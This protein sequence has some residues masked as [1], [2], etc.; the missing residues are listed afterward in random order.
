V[1]VGSPTALEQRREP[2]HSLAMGLR[3]T[4]SVLAQREAGVGVSDA[5]LHHLRM[6]TGSADQ[7][8]VCVCVCVCMWVCVAAVVQAHR[9]P[10]RLGGPLP[11]QREQRRVLVRPVRCPKPAGRAIWTNQVAAS[12]NVPFVTKGGQAVPLR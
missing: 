9:H 10:H 7:T 11:R 1:Q 8:D 4:A 5:L 12:Q 6:G 3:E 2:L